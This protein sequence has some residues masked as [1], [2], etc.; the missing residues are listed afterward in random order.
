MLDDGV[1]IERIRAGDLQAFEELYNR[2]R[3]PVF[4]TALAIT[5]DQQAAEEILQD[6]FVRAYRHMDRVD[7]SLPLSP[8]LH[9]IA[10]NL[11]YNWATRRRPWLLSLEGTLEHLAAAACH[12]PERI[13]ENN[14][15]QRALPAGALPVRR[16]RERRRGPGRRMLRSSRGGP[17]ATMNHRQAPHCSNRPESLALGYCV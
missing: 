11:S 15:A 3:R 14:E 1:L 6:C 7:S 2:Y 8:W 17:R 13:A 4:H 10:V 9:R 12:L 16:T 5:H